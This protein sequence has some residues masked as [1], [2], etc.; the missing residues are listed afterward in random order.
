MKVSKIFFFIAIS[1][2]ATKSFSQEKAKSFISFN[3]G[4]SSPT[5]DFS[6]ADAGTF[7]HWNNTAGFAK[8][9]Y[10]LSVDGAYYFLPKI[11]LGG[12]I[13][14]SAHGGF[15]KSDVTKL[16]DSYTD[17]FA[18]DE[19]TVSTTGRYQSLNILIGPYFSFP[20]KKFTLDLRAVAGVITSLSTPQMTVQ[21]E[22]QSAATFKQISSKASAFCWQVGAGFRYALSKHVQFVWRADYFYSEGIKIEN[23]N[24][25]NNAGRFVTRQP[26][27]WMNSSVGL[28]FSLKK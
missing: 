21:L 2:C 5:G 16:G 8:T 12:T 11:G 3:A 17:A 20:I 26:M 15:S 6:K 28:A 27:S 10:A 25:S 1:L 18:V 13:T 24:R 4:I 23:T 19:S 9:G 22:D 14:Y 7:N